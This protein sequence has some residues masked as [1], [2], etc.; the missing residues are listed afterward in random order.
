[1]KRTSGTSGAI[2]RGLTLSYWDPRGGRERMQCRSKYFKGTMAKRSPNLTTD[3]N[4]KIQAAQQSPNRK[5]QG[6][7][8]AY[9][10]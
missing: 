6:N 5:A 8:H 4:L 9:P 1:M 2:S 3:I 7:P 10:S